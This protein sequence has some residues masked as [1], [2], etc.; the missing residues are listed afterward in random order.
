MVKNLKVWKK[1][2]AVAAL[3]LATFSANGCGKE[4]QELKE[5][6]TI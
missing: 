3:T 5:I 2:F 4:E 1:G 6:V